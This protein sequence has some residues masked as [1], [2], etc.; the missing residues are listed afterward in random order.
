M[1]LFSKSVPKA[2][3]PAGN[4]NWIILLMYFWIRYSFERMGEEKNSQY[5]EDPQN[6]E[7]YCLLG[8]DSFRG[9]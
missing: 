3:R 5:I 2:M 8:V 7:S 6:I 9:V 4:Y 1:R